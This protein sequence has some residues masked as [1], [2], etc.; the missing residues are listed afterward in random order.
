[1]RKAGF[2]SILVLLAVA[3]IVEA[4][5]PA[6]IH[7]IGI[8]FLSSASG[9]SA[10][11]DAFR[12]RLRELGYVE[13]KN[14][15]IEWRVSEGKP[16]HELALASELVRLKV[17]LSSGVVRYLYVQPGRRPPLSPLSW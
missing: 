7:R 2:L 1:M 16:D 10:R 4:Q 9:Q 13:G 5:Q 3:V 17:T 15:V 12:Q 6:R 14:L 11:I 8:L